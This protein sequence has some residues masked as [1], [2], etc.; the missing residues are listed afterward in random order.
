MFGGIVIGEAPEIPGF[1]M[2]GDLKSP[3]RVCCCSGFIVERRSK[4]AI[5]PMESD[6]PVTLGPF[7]FAEV[8]GEPMNPL[9][10]GE[11][12]EKKSGIGIGGR[13]DA[14]SIFSIGD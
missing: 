1:S 9:W 5:F 7:V 11:E 4:E 6:P 10:T 8:V 12:D 14:A 2:T 13:T 3:S